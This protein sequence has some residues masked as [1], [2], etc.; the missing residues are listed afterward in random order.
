MWNARVPA[1]YPDLIVHARDVYYVVA[2]A[3][4][5][6]REG[7]RIAV[8]SGGHSWS[9]NHL[10]DGGLLLDLSRLNEERMREMEP[11][12]SGCGLA[13]ENLAH[14]DRIRVQHDPDSRFF[15]GLG[16]PDGM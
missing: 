7:L 14:L 2:A 12:A 13:D 4:L 3:T 6:K 16:R 11:L 5:A 8:R 9:G 10:R 15:S 1:R